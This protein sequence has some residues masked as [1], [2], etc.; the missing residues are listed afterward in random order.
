MKK[1]TCQNCKWLGCY[2]H[3]IILNQMYENDKKCRPMV[4][5]CKTRWSTDR[6]RSTFEGKFG[7][8]EEHE[9][10]IQKKKITYE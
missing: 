3:S 4:L 9:F 5:T 7:I 8:C 10:K 1:A 6:R 2:D